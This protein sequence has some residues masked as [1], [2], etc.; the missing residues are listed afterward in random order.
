MRL[1]HEFLDTY[2]EYVEDTESP[3]IFHIWCAIGGVAACLGRR[4][5]LEFGESAML[6][7]QFILL[8]GPPG[9]RKSTTI[10]ILGSLL[11]ASTNIRFAPSDTAGQRQG[12]IKAIH[13]GESEEIDEIRR[14]LGSA[15]TVDLERIA[16]LQL[17]HDHRDLHAMTVLSDEFG[18]F[19]GQGNLD[20]I[21]FLNRM[22][23]GVDYEYQIKNENRTLSSPLLNIIG[24][25]TPKDI[26][27][28][29]PIEA[30]GQ[31]FMSRL[32]LVYGDRKHKEI[33][34]P[35]RL[36]SDLQAQLQERY[37]LIYNS[38]SG[39]IRESDQA[40]RAMDALYN[41]A[42][43]HN[44]PRFLYYRERRHTHLYKLAICLAAAELSHTIELAHVEL[45][46][47]ILRSTEVGMPEALGEYGLSPLASAKQKMVEFIQAANE[48]VSQDILWIMMQRDMKL[49]DFQNS[50][51]D[52]VNAG[53][54]MQIKDPKTQKVAF[55]YKE[56]RKTE[57]ESI[58][59]H[60]ADP[61][62]ED[63]SA[64]E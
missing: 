43:P 2:L 26:S 36:R 28:T 24:G 29:M 14:E 56:K 4:A 47:T 61:G 7:N 18:S 42:L 31:G 23:D 9:T 58:L 20:M 33:P 62:G 30:T 57:I 45:A 8:V 21:R 17:S 37:S 35:R 53:R 19:I 25:T 64:A 54:I 51:L 55:V 32:V 16:S 22:Y 34:R 48:V 27:L 63:V 41:E 3:R 49:V 15:E 11:R 60:L 46:R 40:S 44:D 12:L 1:N 38:F 59:R 5:Y 52:L 10:N 13:G 39:E 6:P 50:L